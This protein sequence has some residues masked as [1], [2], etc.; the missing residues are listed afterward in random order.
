MVENL[1]KFLKIRDWEKKLLEIMSNITNN[2]FVLFV[3]SIVILLLIWE[4]IGRVLDLVHLISSP[5]IVGQEIVRILYSLTWIEHLL[6]TFGRVTVAFFVSIFV[7]SLIG[8]LVGLTDFW[9]NALGSY[10]TIGLSLPD[11]F[12]VVVVAMWFGV[13]TMT[14]IIAG[15]IIG[16]PF[17]ATS[18]HGAIEDIE[19]GYYEMA[20]AYN[21]DKYHIAKDIVLQAVLPEMFSGARYTFALC[22]KIITLG[23]II[24]AQ[25]GLGHMIDSNLR[26]LNLTGVIAWVA[27]FTAVMLIIEYG[28][29]QQA[30]KRLFN[31]RED[32]KGVI[33]V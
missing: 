23:E 18:L 32:S 6:A 9:E 29:F 14:P 16:F 11:L 19:V 20:F 15:V 4:S 10:I 1:G 25:N 17:L 2:R 28:I 5:F 7:G 27:I 24:A 33:T 3:L 12:V 31:W 22:W 26:S 13:S 21:I 30:E 8:L